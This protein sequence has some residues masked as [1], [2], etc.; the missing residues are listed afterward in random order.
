MRSLPRIMFNSTNVTIYILDAIQS[1]FL[2]SYASVREICNDIS[3]NMG[4]C[5][6]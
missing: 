5:V 4:G 2:K 3:E 1:R 6:G